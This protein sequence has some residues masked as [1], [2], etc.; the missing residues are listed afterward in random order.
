MFTVRFE[1][2]D[3]VFPLEK[4]AFLVISDDSTVIG[5]DKLVMF[6]THKQAGRFVSNVHKK[7]IAKIFQFKA[8]DYAVIVHLEENKSTDVT[9]L[10]YDER[11]GKF[12][13]FLPDKPSFSINQRLD[14]V[15]A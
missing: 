4:G 10:I 9:R 3:K 12:E 14:A 7:D 5:V 8:G 1:V 2:P 11:K 15:A 13:N 6:K